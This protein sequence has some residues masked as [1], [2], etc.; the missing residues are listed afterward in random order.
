MARSAARQ[1]PRLGQREEDP[2][3]DAQ[4]RRQ[5]TVAR[6][7]AELVAQ[8]DWRLLEA[9]RTLHDDLGQILTAAGIRFDLLS[10]QV[11]ALS[12]ELAAEARELQELVEQCLARVRV[13]SIDLNRS[14]ADRLGIKAA[15][16]RLIEKWE[17]GI[18]AG[19]HFTCQPQLKLPLGPSRAAVRMVEF[20][21]ELAANEASCSRVNIKARATARKCTVAVEIWGF[22]SPHREIENE[23][24]WRI[25][26][27]SA[28][29]AGAEVQIIVAF[30]AGDVTIMKYE[31]PT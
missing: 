14:T 18:R 7:L 31:F 22:G 3:F 1:V 15:V 10:S 28:A 6:R 23:V 19:I 30:K 20:A 11:S 9:G 5:E 29:L 25:L 24:A 27:A 16:E 12:P 4:E 13:L 17:P 26:K 21:L 2:R 8:K